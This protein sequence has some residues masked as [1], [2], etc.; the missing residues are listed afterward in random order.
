MQVRV[1]PRTPVPWRMQFQFRHWNRR[2]YP[3]KHVVV[4]EDDLSNQAAIMAKLSTMFDR[5]GHVQVSLVCGGL[6]AAGIMA[7]SKVD[8]VILDHDMPEG[9]G[10]DLLDWMKKQGRSEVPVITFSG[11]PENNVRMSGLGAHHQ[12]SKRQVLEGE[13]D[14]LIMQY[15][16]G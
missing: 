16:A 15:L 10:A 8:L 14:A 11:I 5:E 1:L 12:F 6:G 9:N 13:A 4:C 2:T 3:T 7:W